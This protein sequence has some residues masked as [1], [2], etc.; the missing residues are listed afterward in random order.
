[1]VI[2]GIILKILAVATGNLPI[3]QIIIEKAIKENF[4]YGFFLLQ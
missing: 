2:M 1:M 4:L 3:N